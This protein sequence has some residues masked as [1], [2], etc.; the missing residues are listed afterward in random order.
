MAL[1]PG[2]FLKFGGS[3]IISLLAEG[4]DLKF[5]MQLRFAMAHDKK[6]TCKGKVVLA[7]DRGAPKHLGIPFIIS[8]TDE[9]SNFKFGM[10]L[11]FKTMAYRKITQAGK[12]G[13]E[14]H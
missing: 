7:R 3:L 11:G 1:G 6:D 14:L 8:A 13:V 12:V 9:T 4:S 5:G 10:Q 2:N